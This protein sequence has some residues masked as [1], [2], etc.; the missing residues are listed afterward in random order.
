WGETK[1]SDSLISAAAIELKFLK[2]SANAAVTDGRHSV[3]KDLENL[4]EYAIS[5]ANPELYLCEIVASTNSNFIENK[6]EKFSI[7]NDTIIQSY[8]QKDSTYCNIKISKQYDPIKWDEYGD[9]SFLKI[10]PKD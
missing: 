10:H 9:Y 3:Y 6:G 4:E 2:K 1:N 8:T 5:V 7:G